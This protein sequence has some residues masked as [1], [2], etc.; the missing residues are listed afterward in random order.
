[1]IALRY[2]DVC[3]HSAVSAYNLSTCRPELQELGRA[4]IRC[5]PKYLDHAIICGHRNEADQNEAFRTGRSQKRWPDGD[6]NTLPSDALDLRP[7]SP[8]DERD[9]GDGVRFARIVG[10]WEALAVQL[11]IPIRLGL[12]WNMDGRS[13][14]EQFKDLGHIEWA[15]PK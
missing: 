15:G 3:R 7:A 4:A 1:V 13:R 6:H 10:F 14:D 8:F 2:L 11:Q 12:D 5:A 9:W